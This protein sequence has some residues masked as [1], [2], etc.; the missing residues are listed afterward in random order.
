MWDNDSTGNG[1]INLVHTEHH[2]S[3]SL[4]LAGKKKISI[5]LFSTLVQEKL[6][7]SFLNKTF[8]DYGEP[9][10]TC[11]NSLLKKFSD[12]NLN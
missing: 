12:L 3:Q 8:S 6:S 1:V 5:S 11:L 2:P 7:Q 10:E 4:R 9:L